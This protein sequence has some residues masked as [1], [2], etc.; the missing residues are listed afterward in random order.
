M[1]HRLCH[2]TGVLSLTVLLGACASG[3]KIIANQDPNADFS[4][5]K[6]FS[7]VDPLSTDRAGASG[8]LS[9][10]LIRATSAEFEARGMK[11]GWPDPDLLIDFVVSAQQKIKSSSQPSSSATMHRGRGGYGTWTGYSMTA[12][13]TTATQ[14]T[15]GTVAIDVIDRK[16]KQV[17]W[18]AAATGRV[19]EKTRDNLQSAVPIVVGEMFQQYPI[20][21]PK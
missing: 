3:P 2:A 17:V 14:T 20:P 9:G 8:V 11:R 4:V 5:Y 16:R 18:E 10:F 13:T 1:R 21:R 6:T 12:S 7:F 19:T 15:E